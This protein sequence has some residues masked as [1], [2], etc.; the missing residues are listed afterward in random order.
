[1]RGRDLQPTL[2][3]LTAVRQAFCDEMRR[4]FSGVE[5][6][7]KMLASYQKLPT[8]REEGCYLAVDFGG[9]WVRCLR[10]SLKEQKWSIQRQRSFSLTEADGGRDYTSE[11]ASGDE[12]FDRI[13][14]EFVGMT[15]SD[16]ELVL[17]HVFSFPGIQTNSQT[18]TLLRWTKEIKTSG[19]IGKDVNQ[20]LQEGL[21]RA[22]RPLIKAVSVMN[23]TVAT[24]LTGSFQNS[25][26]QIGGICGT[27]HN[28]CYFEVNHPRGPMVVNLESGNFNRLSQTSI[29]KLLDYQS[30][31]PGQQLL[32]KQVS[33]RYLGEVCRLGL[34]TEW[35]TKTPTWLRKPDAVTASDV[36]GW[37]ELGSRRE[38]LNSRGISLLEKDEESLFEWAQGSLIR[39]ASLVSACL[40]GIADYLNISESNPV[41]V[42]I[43]GSLYLKNLN[44]QKW[45]L[46]ALENLQMKEKVFLQSVEDGSGVGGA[47]GAAMQ[48]KK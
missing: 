32:E 6:S 26:I 29:D 21:N 36:I 2:E 13:A 3:T 4:G 8:G 41:G 28:L 12:L 27:G 47:I 40:A 39:S 5:S 48:I 38:W 11:E 17:G 15:N 33:G 9:T 31:D 25:A 10:I 23:D 45:M 19:M 14:Q 24:L 44:Y 43:D 35:G 22:G 1:M 37:L 30:H 18:L 20:M 7:F 42:G 16:E 34:F 46:K